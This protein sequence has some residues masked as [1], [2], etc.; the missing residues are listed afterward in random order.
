MQTIRSTADAIDYL[1]GN[2]AAAELFRVKYN[3]I[4]NWRTFGHFP[5]DTYVMIQEELN[6][7]NLA[8][9]PQ[10]W[11]MRSRDQPRKRRRRKPKGQNGG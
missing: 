2:R 10:L 4:T 5:P 9:A 7:R 3:N 1:G 6:K 11:K 8:G